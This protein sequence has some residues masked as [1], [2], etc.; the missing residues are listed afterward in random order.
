MTAESEIWKGVIG[1]EAHYEVSSLGRMR[2]TSG[3]R[4]KQPVP[5][6]D[7]YLQIAFGYNSSGK[8]RNRGLHCIVAEAFIPNPENSQYVLHI[9]G[10]KT[11]NEVSNLRWATMTD[12]KRIRG[13]RRK[14]HE[15]EEP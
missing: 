8:R 2:F 15:S 3:G 4:M 1:Y 7:G 6:R 5:H 11:N 14:S 10:D 12:I 9:D 13:K